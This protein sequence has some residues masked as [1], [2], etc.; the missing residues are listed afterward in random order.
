[1]FLISRF[2]LSGLY[3]NLF[4]T[5]QAIPWESVDTSR[6]LNQI[7]SWNICAQQELEL[8][9]KKREMCWES[10]CGWGK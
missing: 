7:A 6:K 10:E 5:D 8:A 2:H 3:C 1:M 9:S 4:Y